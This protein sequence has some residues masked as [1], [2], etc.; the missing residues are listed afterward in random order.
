MLL[1]SI[2]SDPEITAI[3]SNSTQSAGSLVLVS[4]TAES[5]V[6]GCLEAPDTTFYSFLHYSN[7]CSNGKNITKQRRA[8]FARAMNPIVSEVN[9]GWSR[10]CYWR[11]ISIKYVKS[12]LILNEWILPKQHYVLA[13]TNKA[14]ELRVKILHLPHLFWQMT[15]K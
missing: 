2:S 10:R 12:E 3:H 5:E 14:R 9:W 11:F 7:I 1:C 15:S 4:L 6:K 8:Q 13:T